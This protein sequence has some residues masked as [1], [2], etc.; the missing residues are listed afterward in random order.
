MG[1]VKG[2]VRISRQSQRG[3]VGTAVELISHGRWGAGFADQRL[4]ITEESIKKRC[5]IIIFLTLEMKKFR[6]H[7]KNM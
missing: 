6:A 4:D 5:H 3:S 2:E 1:E 7:V